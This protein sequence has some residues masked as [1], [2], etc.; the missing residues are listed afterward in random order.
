M[1]CRRPVVMYL[2]PLVVLSG[3]CLHCK[4]RGASDQTRYR[5]AGKF[6]ESKFQDNGH[7]PRF[8]SLNFVI[9]F[10]IRLVPFREGTFLEVQTS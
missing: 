9:L 4:S 2:A 6:C 10:K 3:L 1:S 8:C 7:N 5:V